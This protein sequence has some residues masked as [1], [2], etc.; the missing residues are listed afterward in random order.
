[1]C[2][3]LEITSMVFVNLQN[4]APFYVSLENQIILPS[5]K[6]LIP[7]I[8]HRMILCVTTKN[9]PILPTV[10]NGPVQRFPAPANAFQPKTV[11]QEN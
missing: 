5:T 6:K 3:H 8:K 1:M 7:P 11:P 10:R 9:N 2:S 4:F